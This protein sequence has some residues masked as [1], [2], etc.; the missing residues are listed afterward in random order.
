MILSVCIIGAFGL[1]VFCIRL[2]EKENE[3]A[4]AS[5]PDILEDSHIT[6]LNTIDKLPTKTAVELLEE[7]SKRKRIELQLK[8]D[9]L[10]RDK[11]IEKRKNRILVNRKLE[12]QKLAN[13]KLAN[14]ILESEKLTNPRLANRILESEKLANPIVANRILES[15]KLANP[16]LA[17][18]I[19]E[20]EKLANPRLANRILDS[21][22]LENRKIENQKFGLLGEDRYFVENSSN[23]TSLHHQYT[24]TVN[25]HIYYTHALIDTPL[26]DTICDFFSN[27]RK[28]TTKNTTKAGNSH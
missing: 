25:Y 3:N 14:R 6:G 9:N 13:P 20:S 1:L 5:I 23:V 28:N 27:F 12:N 22:K 26:I 16:K 21:E 8:K 19:S 4:Q 18:R 15:E 10:R 17:N 11:K 2:D 24:Y 7:S